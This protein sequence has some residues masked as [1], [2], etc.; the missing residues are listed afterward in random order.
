MRFIGVN[1]FHVNYIIENIYNIIVNGTAF[2]FQHE[3]RRRIS[4]KLIIILYIYTDMH[5]FSVS[6]NQTSIG[7]ISQR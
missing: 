4:F 6:S 3:S 2:V 7:F 5:I 1:M